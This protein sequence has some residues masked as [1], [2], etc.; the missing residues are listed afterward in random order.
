M[1]ILF[2]K[3]KNIYKSTNV[4]EKITIDAVLPRKI[5]GDFYK[6]VSYWKNEGRYSTIVDKN[7]DIPKVGETILYSDFKKMIIPLEKFEE[8]EK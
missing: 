5:N 2:E 6:Q 1:R 4:D 8:I 3:I 7:A